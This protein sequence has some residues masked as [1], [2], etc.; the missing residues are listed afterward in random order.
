MVESHEGKDELLGLFPGLTIDK[1][2]I[3]IACGIERLEIYKEGL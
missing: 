3:K 2:V 1:I